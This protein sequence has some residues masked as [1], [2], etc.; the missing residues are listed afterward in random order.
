MGNISSKNIK[1]YIK[2][3]E[4]NLSNQK[5]DTIDSDIFKGLSDLTVM[6]VFLNFKYKY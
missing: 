5:V 3:N 1:K 6:Q 2:G 4:V